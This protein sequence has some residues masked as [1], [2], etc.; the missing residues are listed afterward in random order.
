MSQGAKPGERILYSRNE[1]GEVQAALKLL[2]D[3]KIEMVSPADFEIKG[4]KIKIE[5]ESDLNIKG[6]KV[7]IEGQVEA[8]GG[9]FKCK[10][11]AAPTGTG[12]LCAL[13]L[14]PVTGAAHVGD[15]AT[16]T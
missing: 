4:K 14:C 7:K 12:C 5:A 15:T 9:T 1:D 13:S 8:T 3:G 2:N 16:N 11:S 10:G 6:Q